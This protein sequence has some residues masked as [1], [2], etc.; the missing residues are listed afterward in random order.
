M[1]MSQLTPLFV[2]ISVCALPHFTACT[3][4]PI[5]E[6]NS[7]HL[8]DVSETESAMELVEAKFKAQFTPFEPHK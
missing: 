3:S 8:G 7:T 6:I 1:C 5:F 2:R 4:N